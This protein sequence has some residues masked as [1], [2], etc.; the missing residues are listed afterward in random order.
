MTCTF[1][2]H[3]PEAPSVIEALYDF[4][5]VVIEANNV[6]L[7]RLTMTLPLVDDRIP[8]DAK[9]EEDKDQDG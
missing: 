7:E 3:S 4:Q 1:I 5:L 8:V 2:S 6:M 9:K